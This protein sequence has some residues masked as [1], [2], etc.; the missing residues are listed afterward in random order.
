MGNENGNSQSLFQLRDRHDLVERGEF[1]IQLR[2][3]YDLN[4]WLGGNNNS[5]L[6]HSCTILIGFMLLLIEIFG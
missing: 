2:K 6:L 4:S 5:I 3:D 1:W